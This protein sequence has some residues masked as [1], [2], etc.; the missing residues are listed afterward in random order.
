MTTPPLSF[1]DQ[2]HS[3]DTFHIGS[4]FQD[5]MTKQKIGTRKV[6]LRRRSAEDSVSTSCANRFSYFPP[7]ILLRRTIF[8]FLGVRLTQ[9]PFFLL[10]FSFFLA[11]QDKSAATLKSASSSD[12]FLFLHLDPAQNVR[13]LTGKTSLKYI[14]PLSTI[15]NSTFACCGLLRL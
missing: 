10:S 11:F 8:S 5:E 14:S 13:R 2:M 15:L 1:R 6:L 7:I 4:Q 9:G 3:S 12:V